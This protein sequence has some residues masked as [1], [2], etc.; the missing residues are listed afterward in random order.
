MD[1]DK[2]KKQY[3]HI[4][5]GYCGKEHPSPMLEKTYQKW[6]L[7]YANVIAVCS[8]C[9]N[10]RS[11]PDRKDDEIIETHVDI[12]AGWWGYAVRKAT[13]DELES[14]RRAKGI[15]L[16]GLNQRKREQAENN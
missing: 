2:N 9:L 11:M 15:L 14:V 3:V 16:E 4:R 12:F 7:N 8:D 5:C 1:E 6:L 13:P 10:D